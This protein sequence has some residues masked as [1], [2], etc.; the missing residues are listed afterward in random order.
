MNQ[1]RS[2]QYKK[3]RYTKLKVRQYNLSIV[4]VNVD[5]STHRQQNCRSMNPCRSKRLYI[6]DIQKWY[7]DNHICRSLLK[8]GQHEQTS[9]NVWQSVDQWINVDQNVYI[10]LIYKSDILT[11]TFVD[12]CFFNGST[13]EYID[14]RLT[15]CRSMN[16]CRSIQYPNVD[17]LN[18]KSDN[19]TC[20]LL[21]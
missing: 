5:T 16:Q 10:L 20:R 12:C 2:I 3:C 18:L 8:M 7:F 13:R 9:T 19:T 6:V 14:K 15:N 4:A 21:R 17:I 1:C 11:I